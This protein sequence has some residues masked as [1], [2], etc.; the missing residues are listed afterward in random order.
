M[1]NPLK[2]LVGTDLKATSEMALEAAVEFSQHV[3]C[4]IEVFHVITELPYVDDDDNTN[5]V[6]RLYENLRKKVLKELE[7]KVAKLNLDKVKI[8]VSMGDPAEAI[9]QEAE[10]YKPDIVFITPGEHHDLFTYFLGTTQRK[11]VRGLKY[12]LMAIKGHTLFEKK[13]VLVPVD[14]S[15]VSMEGLKR[16]LEFAK[17]FGLKITAVHAHGA[18]MPGYM[19]DIQGEEGEEELRELLKGHE[20]KF[21]E[22]LA[23]FKEE[24]PIEDVIFVQGEPGAE[25]CKLADKYDFIVMASQSGS[26]WT[27]NL[28]GSTAEFVIENSPKSVYVLKV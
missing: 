19:K 8:R 1:N 10:D 17:A 5:R 4:E 28:L 20:Q 11:L 21:D 13:H 25:I 18:F 24:D 23:P 26:S 27:K 16:A 22:M 3:P 15:D 9:V 7:S 12:P 6:H 2:I 14:L